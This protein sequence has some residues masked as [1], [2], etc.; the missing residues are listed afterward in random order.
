M[1]RKADMHIYAHRDFEPTLEHFR[2]HFGVDVS[3]DIVFHP[4]TAVRQMEIYNDKHLTVEIIPLRHSIP[5]VGFLFREKKMMLNMRKEAIERYT[6]GIKEIRNIKTGMDH[7]TADGHVI[8]NARLTMPPFKPR[9]Y[10]F[11]TDTLC[12]SKLKTVLQDV[13]LLYFEATFSAKD[14]KLAKLTGHS[15]SEQAAVLAKQSNIGKLLIGHFS[16]RYKSIAP[17]LKEA[18]AVFSNTEAVS[19]GDKF[20][21]DHVRIESGS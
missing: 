20:S 19:D 13:D 4:F 16:T 21:I 3:F 18:R 12:F 17:L 6:L 9:S 7:I 1:G 5:V 2:K 14:K 15:T 10:A 8:P 11:C